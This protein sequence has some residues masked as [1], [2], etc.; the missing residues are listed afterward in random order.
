MTHGGDLGRLARLAGCEPEEIIDFS[1]NINPVGPPPWLRREISAHVSG[2]VA[3]PDPECAQLL[4][5]ASRRYGVPEAQM[6]PGNGSTELLFALPR[7]TGYKRAV[8]PAPA[9]E[10]YAK[11]ALA[12]GL[13][14]EEPRLSPRN[15]FELDYDDLES[16][17]KRPAMVFLCRPNNPT[18]AV[19]DTR[20]LRSLISTRKDSLFVIDEA[21]A[22]FDERMD[23]FVANRPENVAVLASLTK[24]FAIPGLRLG[25]LI[26]PE[27]LAA[28]VR[29]IIGPWSVGTLAQAVGAKALAD[30]DYRRKTRVMV[31]IYREELVK[32]LTGTKEQ[33]SLG[34]LTRQKRRMTPI[35]FRSEP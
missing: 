20:K 19:Y 15:G 12:A 30:E 4:H 16:R 24:I 7:A 27:P 29:E 18:G 6:V 34:K 32:G 33:S 11:A 25:L 17:L 22:G 14:V 1:A 13:A 23:R 28:R 26:C 31:K 3:Y 9:Y 8:I 2:L 21:F 10:D 35:G 5:A